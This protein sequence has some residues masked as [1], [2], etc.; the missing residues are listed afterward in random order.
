MLSDGTDVV[1]FLTKTVVDKSG[2]IGLDPLEIVIRRCSLVLSTTQRSFSLCDCEDDTTELELKIYGIPWMLTGARVRECD[3]SVCHMRIGR[4]PDEAG[5]ITLKVEINSSFIPPLLYN[6]ETLP[7]R[8]FEYH[9][10]DRW[11][12]F[13]IYKYK[14]DE[15]IE[16]ILTV[17]NYELTWFIERIFNDEPIP[18][19]RVLGEALSSHLSLPHAPCYDLALREAL[20]GFEIWSLEPD[21]IEIDPQKSIATMPPE[22]LYED[23]MGEICKTCPKCVSCEAKHPF[24]VPHFPPQF[25]V[26][27]SFKGNHE[28]HH[29]REYITDNF[30]KDLETLRLFPTYELTISSC[31]IES[32]V[33]NKTV[34]VCD[35]Y[36]NKTEDATFTNNFIIKNIEK[37]ASA[38]SYRCGSN[39]K[40]ILT[41]D[42]KKV[43]GLIYT[44]PDKDVDRAIILKQPFE[45]TINIAFKT[46]TRNNS[47]SETFYAVDR[48]SL[49]DFAYRHVRL[50][51]PSES[52]LILP[53][54]F[55]SDWID[56]TF[57][58]C[59]ATN[60]TFRDPGGV[61]EYWDWVTNFDFKS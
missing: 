48:V 46:T 4:F 16:N 17:K 55:L 57:K 9:I 23:R 30:R 49:A 56:D 61:V 32:L 47:G 27:A 1:H 51:Q 53:L 43:S 19:F 7:V 37:V 28:E 44:K 36:L 25:L 11:A 34:S 20:T 38:V 3:D 24:T 41:V 31:K 8:K 40:C 10:S 50:L 18:I 15:G 14:Y 59:Y 26:F 13:E 22:L 39:G 45:S 54:L 35:C 42:T 12:T 58:Y 21:F 52:E 2:N 33:T 29:V 60:Q 6:Q 5:E